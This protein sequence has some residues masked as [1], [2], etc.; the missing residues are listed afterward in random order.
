MQQK[1]KI[2]LSLTQRRRKTIT[3]AYS[4]AN[5]L[6]EIDFFYIDIHGN[7]KFRFKNAVSNKFVYSFRDKGELLN[8]F[9]KFGWDLDNTDFESEG[10]SPGD[11]EEQD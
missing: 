8:L 6:P 10:G 2:K 11:N 5:K 7:L 3:Y 9:E 4:N 1:T